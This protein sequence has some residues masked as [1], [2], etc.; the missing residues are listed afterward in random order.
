MELYEKFRG[1]DR[2]DRRE[3]FLGVDRATL[4]DLGV[5]DPILRRAILVSVGNEGE[6][7]QY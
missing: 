5:L 6:T 1:F 4:K 2:E 3:L 7:Q